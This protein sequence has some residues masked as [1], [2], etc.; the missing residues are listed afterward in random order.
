MGSDRF[1]G[2]SVPSPFQARMDKWSV[3]LPFQARMDTW[4]QAELPDLLSVKQPFYILVFGLGQE[5]AAKWLY[6][7]STG[8]I[9]GAFSTIFRGRLVEK[10]PGANCG[11]TPAQNNKN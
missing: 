6:N 3:P 10:A 5:L 8:L 11:S 1:L 9:L 4:L 2:G 7:W